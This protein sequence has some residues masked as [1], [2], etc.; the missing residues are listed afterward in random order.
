[1]VNQPQCLANS[2]AW[3]NGMPMSM[4][5]GCGTWGGNIA[6]E[7]ITWKNFLNYTW[8]AYEIEN[9]MPTD[10]DLFGKVMAD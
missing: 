6:S 5:L 1:M 9:T 2:G 8:V 3:T 7:N 4:T 10:E